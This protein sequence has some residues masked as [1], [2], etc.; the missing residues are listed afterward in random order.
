[1]RKKYIKKEWLLICLMLLTSCS[2]QKQAFATTSGQLLSYTLDQNDIPDG[3]YV[4]KGETLYPILKEGLVTN[5]TTMQWFNSFENLIPELGPSDQLVIIDSRRV[6]D[7][8]EFTKME[9]IGHT[10][11]ILFD[12][13]QSVTKNEAGEQLKKETITFSRYTNPYSPAGAYIQE[14][15]S[16]NAL[17]T[18][19][20]TLEFTSNL[21]T[22]QGVL[23]GL[24]KNAMYKFYYY[25]GTTYKNIDLKADTHIY[26]SDYL[27]KSSTYQRMK[28]RYFIIDLPQDMEQGY[29]VVDEVGMFLYSK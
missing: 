27:L 7:T 24:E 20:N 15:I 12:V 13:K 5:P 8:F 21:L 17:I 23:R 14:Y 26:V 19:V 1:M 25:E 16:P 22:A 11:G 9:D 4:M 6:N 2:G 29:Y 18:E 3:Y 10:V 28:D